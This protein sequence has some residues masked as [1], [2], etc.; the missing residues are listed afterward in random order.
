MALIQEQINH[1]FYE[2]YIEILKPEKYER[3][4]HDRDE[5]YPIIDL[6]I[7]GD[8]QFDPDSL[9]QFALWL[10]QQSYHVEQFY[11]E[12]GNKR[13]SNNVKKPLKKKKK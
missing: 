11:D 8:A 5:P 12:L 6:N 1:P 2:Y 4:N 3:E 9:R 7:Y 10:I 13:K